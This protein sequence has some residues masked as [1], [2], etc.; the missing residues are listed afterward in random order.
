M[1]GFEGSFLGRSERIDSSD[2]LEC[3]VCWWVYDPQRGDPVWQIPAGTAFNALPQHWRCPNCDA[4]PSQFMVLE[5]GRAP[6]ADT[7]APSTAERDLAQ[8]Q[9]ALLAGYERVA[10]RMRGLAVYNH[11]LVVDVPAL[12]RCEHGTV[13]VLCTPWCMNLL[14]FTEDAASLR[15]GSSREHAFPSG[16]YPFTASFLS[17]VG[18]F[19]SCSLFSPM[20]V[21]ESPE[22][23]HAVAGETLTALFQGEETSPA[24]DAESIDPGRRRM[25]GMA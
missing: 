12:C 20:D 1:S 6:R 17:D 3:G 8:L 13:G 22:A 4:A 18:H 9:A 11:R 23:V 14:L 15:E 16:V 19:E 2:R 7:A 10:E 24:D 5:Q 21:F 25:L